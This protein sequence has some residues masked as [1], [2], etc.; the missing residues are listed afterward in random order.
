MYYTNLGFTMDF[1]LTLLDHSCLWNTDRDAVLDV[2]RLCSPFVCLMLN[3]MVILLNNV[4]IT[5]PGT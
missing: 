2:F 1:P 5:K 3:E 4:S